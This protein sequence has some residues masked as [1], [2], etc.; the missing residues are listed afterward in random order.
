MNK[1]FLRYWLLTFLVIAAGSLLVS[2]GIFETIKEADVTGISFVILG[3]YCSYVI[4]IGYA[5]LRLTNAKNYLN[6]GWFVAETMLALGMIGTVLGFILMLGDSMA[7]IDIN[8]ASKT[9]EVLGA[10]A[11]GMSTALYTTAIGLIC[12]TL[13]K[14]KLINL[15][16]GVTLSEVSDE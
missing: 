1:T 7:K 3:I 6:V 4:I 12:S 11:A 15:E 2:R 5:S 16:I 8:D 9:T 14:I 10:M 13:L